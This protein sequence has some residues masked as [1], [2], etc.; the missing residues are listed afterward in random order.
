[1]TYMFNGGLYHDACIVEDLIR[2]GELSPAA[3]D[4]AVDEVMEQGREANAI[5]ENHGSEEWPVSLSPQE[6]DEH[7]DGSCDSCLNL[8]TDEPPC[9]APDPLKRQ[10]Y[11]CCYRLHHSGDHRWEPTDDH[12]SVQADNTDDDKE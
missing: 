4:M 5:D 7:E 8:L 11:A 1:M 12:W 2:A 6:E 3:R 9:L 10:D